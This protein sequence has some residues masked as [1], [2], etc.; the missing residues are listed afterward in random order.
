M[1]VKRM[2]PEQPVCAGLGGN[3]MQ[4]CLM[5]FVFMWILQM[6]GLV[7]G[8]DKLSSF[9]PENVIQCDRYGG[10]SVLVWG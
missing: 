4:F 2:L 7:F 5:S 8:E 3:G 1:I 6:D 9:H 10:G